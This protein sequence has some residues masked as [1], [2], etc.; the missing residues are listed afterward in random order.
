MGLGTSSESGSD[1]DNC[2]YNLP[3]GHAFSL[4][5]VVT[6]WSADRTQSQRLIKVRNPWRSE[7]G[8]TGSWKDDSPIWQTV[9]ADGLTFAQQAGQ[10][11]ADDG[12]VHMTPDEV[13][14]AFNSF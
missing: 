6:V 10:T 4:I 1:K 9:G 13:A 7:N 2:L 11:N 8:Y 5:G 3:C 12:M 14:Q